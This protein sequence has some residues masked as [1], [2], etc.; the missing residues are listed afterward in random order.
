MKPWKE[1]R[2]TVAVIAPKAINTYPKGVLSFVE[3]VLSDSR[4]ISLDE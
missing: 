1:F 3:P 2:A 4:R